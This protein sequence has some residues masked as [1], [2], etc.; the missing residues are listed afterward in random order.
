MT[1][2]IWRQQDGAL[3]NLL[4][5]GYAVGGYVLGWAGLFAESY[6]INA[7]ATLLLAHAMVI[8][9]YLIHECAHN[10]IFADNRANARLGA[11]L[12]WLCGAAYGRYEDIRHKHFRHHVDRADVVAFDYRTRLARHPWLLRVVQGLEWLYIPAVDIVMHALVVI[13]PFVLPTRRER[14]AHVLAVLLVRTLLLGLVAWFS[15]KALLLYFLAYMLFMHVMRFMDV[16]QHTFEVFPTLEAARGPEAAKFDRDFEHRNT[17]SNLISLR[18]PWL[19]LLTLNFGYHNAHHVRPTAPWY[20]LPG[21]HRELF[22]DER[23][24]VLTVSDLLR[25]YHRYRVARIVNADA[26]ELDVGNGREFVG[27]LGVSFLTAH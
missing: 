22:P 4:A 25:S 11:V 15:L 2:R 20:T 7:V 1:T 6:W 12:A 13:L 14:R 18:H 21:L 24:Q 10:T 9:A 16:H 27:V 3:P 19:N 8:G 5:I 26:P 17:Y 23:E